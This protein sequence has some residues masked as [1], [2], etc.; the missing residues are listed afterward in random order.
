M[1]IGTEGRAFR[2]AEP[3]KCPVQDSA[4]RN[5]FAF[6]AEVGAGSLNGGISVVEIATG[7][8]CAD[9]RAERGAAAGGQS[10]AKKR[11]PFALW[12]ILLACL[13]W[14]KTSITKNNDGNVKC[15]I[16]KW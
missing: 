9:R 12:A 1:G 2:S 14:E 3:L 10:I 4:W 16:F 8:V 11:Q 15:H 5:V 13:R 6:L 7:D